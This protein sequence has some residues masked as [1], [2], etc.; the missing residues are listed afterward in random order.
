MMEHFMSTEMF[1][2]KNSTEEE[3]RCT[4]KDEQRDLLLSRF[5][6]MGLF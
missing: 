4:E 5:F 3:E 2:E 1:R 6:M